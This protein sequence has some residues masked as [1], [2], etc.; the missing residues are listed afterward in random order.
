MEDWVEKFSCDEFLTSSWHIYTL[1]Y[2]FILPLAQTYYNLTKVPWIL[3]LNLI[4]VVEMWYMSK[5]MVKLLHGVDLR[6]M[7]Y[8]IHY[9]VASAHVR[10]FVRI[11]EF[12][13]FKFW[14]SCWNG[15]VYDSMIYCELPAIL[16]L[17]LSYDM[18]E[19]KYSLGVGKI[20]R[21][22]FLH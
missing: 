19:N 18:F 1:I 13:A 9:W 10:T 6:V 8:P 17:F 20:D 2:L 4:L 12:G 3:V 14:W 5:F 21:L 11:V 16:I 22:H 15:R 7:L